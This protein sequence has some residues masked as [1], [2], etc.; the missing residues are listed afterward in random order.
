MQELPAGPLEITEEQLTE[1]QPRVR[2]LMVQRCEKLWSVIDGHVDEHMA[3]DRPI[4]PRML[5]I[6]L[7]VVKM[8]ADVY[9][10]SKPPVTSDEETE[11][12]L[13][14]VL[15]R[16]ALALESL[17]EVEQRL[18]RG[19]AARNGGETEPGASS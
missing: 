14:Q 18:A 2:A 16:R 19:A 12:A 13:G 8:E 5:E 15:D 4:D 1:A 6:G 10:M 17:L 3:G 7:R 9:R 11:E